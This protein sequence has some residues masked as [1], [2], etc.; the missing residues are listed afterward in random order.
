MKKIILLFA[1][2]F[3]LMG[4]YAQDSK[5]AAGNLKTYARNDTIQGWKHTGLTSLT[6]GQTSLQ[7]GG[8]G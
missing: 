4:A 7:L 3:I 6:F 1:G 2:V 8:R 5:T